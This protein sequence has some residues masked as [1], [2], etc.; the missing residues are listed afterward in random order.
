MTADTDFAIVPFVSIVP[1]VSK[2][3]FNFGPSTLQPPPTKKIERH[4]CRS[5]FR[6]VKTLV[7]VLELLSIVDLTYC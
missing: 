1:I 2:K 4:K 3:I 7:K 5:I 6:Y